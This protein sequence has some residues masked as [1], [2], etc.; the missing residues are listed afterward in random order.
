MTISTVSATTLVSAEGIVE[1][2]SNFSPN[3]QRTFSKDLRLLDEDSVYQRHADSIYIEDF[4]SS[5]TDYKIN[6]VVWRNNKLEYVSATTGQIAKQPEEYSAEDTDLNSTKWQNRYLEF[7]GF[8]ASGQSLVKIVEKSSN[9]IYVYT[10]NISTKYFSVT[11]WS[12]PSLT[13]SY[14][15]GDCADCSDGFRCITEW[16]NASTGK[17]EYSFLS[18]M[19]LRN[20]NDGSCS[21]NIS[22]SS[23][24]KDK[25]GNKLE[26]DSITVG[27]VMYIGGIP[28]KIGNKISGQAHKY[29]YYRYKE[30]PLEGTFNLLFNASLRT[31]EEEAITSTDPYMWLPKTVIKR[32]AKFY[33]RTNV[34]APQE[35]K[36]ITEVHTEPLLYINQIDWGWT[37]VEPSQK[38]APLDTKAYTKLVQSNKVKYT[39]KANDYFDM[40]AV[41]KIYAS[42]VVVKI[43]GKT[44]TFH[45]NCT[46]VKNGKEYK[47]SITD[48][49]Y[50][51][52]RYPKGTEVEVTFYPLNGVL[53]LGLGV[54]GD[55][56]DLGLTLRKFEV[57]PKNFGKYEQ[58]EFGNVLYVDRAKLRRVTYYVDVASI[59]EDNLL[60]NA[61][62]DFVSARLTENMGKIVIIDGNDNITNGSFDN[63][64]M[65]RTVAMIGRF[66]DPKLNK[67]DVDNYIKANYTF[68]AEEIV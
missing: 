25:N 38:L 45:P 21:T 33:I 17:H 39:L 55:S 44:T 61:D 66:R 29:K 22:H 68:T 62:L 27:T 15:A 9:E 65:Y 63:E 34:D 32:G 52:T 49:Y 56:I 16:T 30:T 8:F 31:T 1:K 5:K 4:D 13:G 18:K 60:T 24:A 3:N 40:L 35:T 53:E 6:D 51:G 11:K 19:C 10:I 50:L 59:T 57:N 12:D 67:V 28:V 7:S 2:Y 14:S 43:N 54:L 48:F 20:P 41:A 64:N 23:F 46:S 42:K 36:E 26:V 47:E 58:D 37:F